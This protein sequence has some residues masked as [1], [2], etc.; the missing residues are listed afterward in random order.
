MDG[1]TAVLQRISAIQQRFM[2][3][4]GGVAATGAGPN[5]FA[6]VWQQ[7]IAR[8]TAASPANGEVHGKIATAARAMG[9]DPR[10][11]QAVAMAE[12]GMDQNAVSPTGAVGVMQLMP[13]TAAALGVD[14]TALDDNIRG[15]VTYLQ[16][17]MARFHGNT[18]Y[19]LAAYNAG[20]GAVEQYHGVP[21]YRETQE[22]VS[23]V[24]RLY[25][26]SE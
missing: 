21:P 7:T 18:A 23:K 4:V 19:A 1:M 10:L 11:A 14:P 13:E 16:Q 24:L 3:G 6:R 5:G 2:P 8:Q 25:H 26:H 20:P 22:Y 12:S 9:V 15:G 17:L